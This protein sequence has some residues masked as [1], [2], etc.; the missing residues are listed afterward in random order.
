[1][2]ITAAQRFEALKREI[3]DFL[4]FY[5]IYIYKKKKIQGIEVRM[6]STVFLISL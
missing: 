4:I 3:F 6:Q 2:H 1:M 5:I